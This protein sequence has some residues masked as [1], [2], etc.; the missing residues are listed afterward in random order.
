MSAWGKFNELA[1][2]LTEKDVSLKLK[3]KYLMPVFRECWYMVARHGLWKRRTRLGWGG[4][5]G[6]WCWWWWWIWLDAVEICN[7]LHKTQQ[8][9]IFKSL[10]LDMN[11]V[12]KKFGIFKTGRQTRLFHAINCCDIRILDL[13]YL[14]RFKSICECWIVFDHFEL[15]MYMKFSNK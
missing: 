2:F 6:L 15:L 9:A 1:P 4:L 8:H 12:R 10:T 5:R 3:G 13:I 11:R 14:Y 7:T